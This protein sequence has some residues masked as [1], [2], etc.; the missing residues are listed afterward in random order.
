MKIYSNKKRS[1]NNHQTIRPFTPIMKKIFLSLTGFLLSTA[2]LNSISSELVPAYLDASLTPEQRVADLLPRMTLEEKVGQMCQY[3][4][5]DHTA[6]SEQHMSIDDL[7]KSDAHGF[8]P[9]L[10]SSQIPAFIETGKVGS[11]LHV[12]TASEA[13]LLQRHAAQSRLGIPLLIGIDAIHGNA[14][15][16]GST[17]YPAP[18]SMAS[19]WNLGLVKQASIETAREMRATGSHWSFTPNVDIARDP[20]WGRVGETF[21]EDPFLVAEMGVATIEGLQQRDFYGPQKVIANAKHW[22]AGGDPINGINLSPMDVSERSLRQDFFPPF[23]RAVDAGV[24]TFMAAHNE[25]NGEPAHGS[26]YLLNDVLREEWGFKGFVVSDWMDIERLHTFHRVANSQKEAVYQ[27]VHAGMDMHMHGPDF[28]EPLV[29]L[30][31]EGRLSEARI[32]ESVGPMLLAKFRLGL[33]E[34][35]YVDESQ[36]EQSVFTAAHQQTALEMARQAIV[37]LTNNDN[38]LPL[39]KNSRVFVTGPNADNHT[40]LGDWVLEQPENN[41]TT[42]LEGLRAVAAS[43]KNIDFYDV[44]K[45]VKNLST[46]DI[47][48]AAKRASQSQVAVVVVGENPLRYDKKGKTSGENVARSSINLIG[49]QLEL[50]QAIHATGT[51]VIVVLVNGRPIAEPWVVDNS[52]AVIEAWEPGAMGGQALAEIIYG[53]TNPSGKLPITVPYSIGH[54]QAIYNHKPS[55]YK[56]K[57]A[58]APTRN[59]FEFGYG[60]S[61]TEFAFSPPVLDKKSIQKTENTN[62]SVTVTNSGDR[63]GYETVQLYVRDNYSEITRPVKELKGFE[64]IY[65]QAG[66]SKRVSFTLEPEMLAYYNRAMEWVVEPG[67]FTLMVGSSSRGADLKSIQL[68]VK[69]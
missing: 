31:N 20:R 42:V 56:H 1:N 21:G 12:L 39:Q 51:P 34:N 48:A 49:R 58:D 62:L 54:T 17:V 7:A 30:V 36:I 24:F 69:D 38:I 11:F 63:A 18:L 14:M 22:V 23:K 68:R 19:S 40:I 8:Y 13:N 15:V 25:I 41:V 9:D 35:P 44:G 67:A 60:L 59:L 10:H 37:L 26:R 6:E 45:Q 66:E 3:V 53:V 5:I 16:S 61:Y 65:L 55:A 43:P 47:L 29:E 57:Y 33:F 2:S 52:A 4:G 28:L 32:D 27:T 50:V 64:K 46:E